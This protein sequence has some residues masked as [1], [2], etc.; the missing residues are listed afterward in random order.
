M[1]K[2]KY[3]S[4]RISYLDHGN[5]TTIIIS[6]RIDRRRESLLLFWILAWTACGAYL[7]YYL[8]TGDHKRQMLIGLIIFISFWFYFEYRIG[9]VFLWRKWGME[10]ISLDEE[11]FIYKRA[12]GKYGKA[13]RFFHEDMSDFEIDRIN[14]KSVTINIED[15]FWFLGGERIKVKGKGKYL[16]FG[17]QLSEK[18]CDDLV[19]LIKKQIAA[20]KKKHQAQ[21]QK[22]QADQSN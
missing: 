5:K 1:K 9:K 10:F 22:E 11:E 4:D 7:L 14:P 15:S 8:A 12:I 19:R 20:H 17:R 13:N 3:I 16:R 2:E 18:E 6:S 21:L